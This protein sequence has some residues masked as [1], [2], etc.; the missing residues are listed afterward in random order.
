MHMPYIGKMISVFREGYK[1]YF[2]SAKSFDLKRI[3]LM[4]IR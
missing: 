4:N 1:F 2:K 3:D